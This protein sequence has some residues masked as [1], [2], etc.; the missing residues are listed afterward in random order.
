MVVATTGGSFLGAM[1]ASA[2]FPVVATIAAGSS[3]VVATTAFSFWG[4]D[5][6]RR[7]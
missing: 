4:G 6:R 7:F 2:S 3:L 5:D 1:T